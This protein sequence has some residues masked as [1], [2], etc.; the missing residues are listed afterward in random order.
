MRIILFILMI[1][2]LSISNANYYSINTSFFDNFD[3]NYLQ[4]YIKEALF[5]NH[6]LKTLTIK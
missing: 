1:K 6:D 4:K 5:N 3:D 2:L